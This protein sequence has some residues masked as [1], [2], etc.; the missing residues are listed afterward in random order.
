MKYKV[1]SAF[2]ITLGITLIIQ[3]LTETKANNENIVITQEETIKPKRL[4]INIAIDSPEDVKVNE[5]DEI[6]KGQIIATRERKKREL[7]NNLSRLKLSLAK[8]KTLQPLPPSPPLEIPALSVLPPISYL[9]YEADIEKKKMEIDFINDEIKVKQEEIDYLSQ[10]PEL[11][12]KVINHEKAKL[13][14]LKQKLVIASKEYQL[15]K[16]KYESAKSERKYQEY[17][18]NLDKVRRIENINQQRQNYEREL[19]LYQQRK[20]EHEIKLN[21]LNNQISLAHEKLQS[22]SNSVSPYSGIVR[23]IKLLSQSPDGT[24]NAEIALM[25]DEGQR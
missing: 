7:D 1:L 15:A 13:N 21:E 9:E 8:I 5:G 14:K 3:P 18:A 16:G 11:D 2:L 25:V 24:I 20:S 23:R 10:L 19:A 17:Q 22:L 12:E 4:N 6:K